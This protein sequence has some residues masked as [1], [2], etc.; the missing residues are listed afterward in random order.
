MALGLCEKAMGPAVAFDAPTTRIYRGG[1]GVKALERLHYLL[2][3]NLGR[4]DVGKPECSALG[5][6]ADLDQL[7]NVKSKLREMAKKFDS[8][9]ES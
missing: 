2:G 4:K 8:D 3:W 7:K 9:T 6:I 5:W 1:D